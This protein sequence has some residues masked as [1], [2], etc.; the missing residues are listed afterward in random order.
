MGYL[1]YKATIFKILFKMPYTCTLRLLLRDEL[2]QVI[3]YNPGTIFSIRK[4]DITRGLLCGGGMVCP[5][6]KCRLR[7]NSFKGLIVGFMS[8]YNIIMMVTRKWPIE[9]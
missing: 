3:R 4:C 8:F 9:V 6:G 2:T 5:P 1:S 7:S